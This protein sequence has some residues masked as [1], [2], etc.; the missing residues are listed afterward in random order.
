V[1]QVFDSKQIEILLAP[2]ATFCS[3]CEWLLI[4]DELHD[5]AFLARSNGLNY[6]VAVHVRLPIGAAARMRGS[7]L[8]GGTAV[9]AGHWC[10]TL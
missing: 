2:P 6:Q 4:L 7:D 5:R 9:P 1:F 10:A 3:N 8:L